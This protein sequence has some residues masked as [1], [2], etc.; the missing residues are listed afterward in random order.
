MAYMTGLKQLESKPTEVPA[1]GDSVWYGVD[2]SKVLLKVSPQSLTDYR[3]APQWCN[4]ITS[5]LLRGDVNAD[6]QVDIAD[7]NILINIMLGKDDADNYD[8]RAYLTDDM[9]VD[10]AD[11]NAA[12]NL[13]LGRQRALRLA[14]EKAAREAAAQAGNSVPQHSAVIQ[15]AIVP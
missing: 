10:I 14:A 2:Q 11:V 8:G 4:F 13:M 6:G 3:N 5:D 9:V 12:I 1:L 15:Q 7:V